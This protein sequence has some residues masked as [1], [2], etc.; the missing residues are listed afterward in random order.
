MEDRDFATLGQALGAAQT[1]DPAADPDKWETADQFKERVPWL[2]LGP[3]AA[4]VGAQ[5]KVMVWVA[6]L[7]IFAAVASVGIF[8]GVEIFGERILWGLLFGPFEEAE[9]VPDG[10]LLIMGALAAGG[11]AA[12]I[13]AN[14]FKRRNL[15]RE[16][17][18]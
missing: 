14:L 3:E 4:S 2:K 7:A 13:T 9:D 12:I 17:D 1:Q 15:A 11:L 18:R 16:R 10:S 5:G 6:G 8:Q